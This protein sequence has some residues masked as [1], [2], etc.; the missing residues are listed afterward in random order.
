LRR[1][2]HA[3]IRNGRSV[4]RE[5]QSRPTIVRMI[6]ATSSPPEV[7]RLRTPARM[8]PHAAGH[9]LQLPRTSLELIEPDEVHLWLVF[10]DEINDS[11]LLQQ[12]RDM[13]TDEER[14]REMLF[15]NAR[16]RHC[17][18]LTRALVRTTL[19]RYANVAPEDWRFF[20]DASGQTRIANAPPEATTLTFSISHKRG[21]IL[22]GIAPRG[23]LG[24]DVEVAT[25]DAPPLNIAETCFSDAEWYALCDVPDAEQ[26][27]RFFAYWTL[28]EAYI[29]ARGTGLSMPLDEFGF[30]LDT[31]DALQFWALPQ[32][33]PDPQMWQFW[34][35]TVGSP[36]RVAAICTER[37]S[38]RE[39]RLRARITVPGVFDRPLQLG[40]LRQ[41]SG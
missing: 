2:T 33:D 30:E 41:S 36:E 13:L 14:A 24:V 22:L 11:F 29:K 27:E 31:S 15:L 10:P 28:K 39:P 6:T 37:L 8:E 4:C 9:F 1:E 16:E 19:S 5:E 21:F 26:A 38:T 20:T 7:C 17:Y 40:M 18:L 25:G 23:A 32:L 35:F 34:Q 3:S 12:Y